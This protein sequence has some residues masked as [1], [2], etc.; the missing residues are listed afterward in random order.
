MTLSPTGIK[1]SPKI[2][3]LR[4]KMGKERDCV[5]ESSVSGFAPP[6]PNLATRKSY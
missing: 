4:E 6:P 2:L 5:W 1:L 3:R